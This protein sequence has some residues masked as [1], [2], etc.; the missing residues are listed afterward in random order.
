MEGERESSNDVRYDEQ[1]LGT[2]VSPSHW[3]E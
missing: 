2:G 3:A 1:G